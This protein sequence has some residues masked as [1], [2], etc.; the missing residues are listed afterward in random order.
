MKGRYQK[1]KTTLQSL[2]WMVVVM[3]CACMNGYAQDVKADLDY[4]EKFAG[5][6]KAHLTVAGLKP[7]RKYAL[8]LNG[9][10]DH[11]SNAILIKL[12]EKY[13]PTGEGQY[14]FKKVTSTK[15]CTLDVDIKQRLPKG[16]YQV[17]FLIKDISS[18]WLTVFAEDL[19]KFEVTEPP[20]S[21]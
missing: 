14:N 10:R 16:E 20:Q 19:V 5:A 13:E 8:C 17:K 7:E 2:A 12:G 4:K 3:C 18:S 15:A 11:P 9:Y 1:M 21:N 6:F